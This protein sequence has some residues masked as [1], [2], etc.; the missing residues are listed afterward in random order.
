MT[1]LSMDWQNDR[2]IGLSHEVVP[3][4]SQDRYL[5]IQRGLLAHHAFMHQIRTHTHV[6]RPGGGTRGNPT[7]RWP[8]PTTR[9]V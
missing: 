2:A 8:H 5:D 9:G 3:G 6:P 7:Q 1:V 4:A